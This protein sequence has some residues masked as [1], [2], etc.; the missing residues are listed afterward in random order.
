M[1]RMRRQGGSLSPSKVQ[2]SPGTIESGRFISNQYLCRFMFLA[3]IV[4]LFY[5]PTTLTRHLLT[6]KRYYE[7]PNQDMAQFCPRRYPGSKLDL[8]PGSYFIALNLHNSEKVVTY[9]IPQIQRLID[10]LGP[11]R[12]FISIYESGSVDNTAQWLR[13]YRQF[14]DSHHIPNEVISDQRSRSQQ[15]H[16]IDYLS[17]I[18]NTV[19][20]PLYQHRFKP[21]YVVFINDVFFCAEDVSRLGQRLIQGPHINMACG[22]DLVSEPHSEILF[23][24]KWAARD[25]TGAILSGN[26]P[27]FSRA[28]D[29]N[30]I[31]AGLPV[32]VY[33]CWNGLTVVKAKV[34][35]TVRFR[36][37]PDGACLSSECTLFCQD[38]WKATPG[39]IIIDPAVVVVYDEYSA[40][41]LMNFPIAG[42]GDSSIPIVGT[43]PNPEPAPLFYDCMP[44]IGVNS[45]ASR[46]RFLQESSSR[47]L[48]C[49]GFGHPLHISNRYDVAA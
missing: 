16:R 8:G 31:K 22:L 48:N 14:L 38:V 9:I 19:M 39:N 43:S 4:I 34:F 30:R 11:D 33:A 26:Y 17:I 47:S 2:C 35:D 3:L 20:A 12:I 42:I 25:I 36:S 41:R 28:Q 46:L 44:M 45:E 1:L 49:W 7:L 27:F 13:I 15:Q 18:R 29:V 23:Y 21:D 40:A 6:Y 32:P 37:A 10:A 5:L 24:D